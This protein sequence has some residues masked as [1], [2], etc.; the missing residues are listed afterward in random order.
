MLLKRLDS[1]MQKNETGSLSYTIYKNYI[2]IN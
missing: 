2:E 1:H